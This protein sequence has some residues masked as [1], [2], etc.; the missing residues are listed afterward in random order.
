[1]RRRRL[2]DPRWSGVRIMTDTD[3]EVLGRIEHLTTVL[4]VPSGR[5][6]MTQGAVGNE[7]MILL[8]GSVEVAVDGDVIAEL[9][10]GEVVGELAVLVDG[11]RTATV[12][13][14]TPA[15]LA[16]VPRGEFEQF[17]IEAPDATRRL[18]RTVAAR[19][20]TT[21]PSGPTDR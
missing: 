15:E 20:V 5:V 19:L 6:L 18:L 3:P 1:M 13:T 8:A 16:V 11:H 9:G 10:A 4:Q 17:L 21:H 2:T 7:F 12:R 14:T